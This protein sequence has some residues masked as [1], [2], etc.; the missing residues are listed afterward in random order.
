MNMDLLE[1][2]R[3]ALQN[4]QN[5]ETGKQINQAELLEALRKANKLL[6][7][8]G[9]VLT[10]DQVEIIKKKLSEGT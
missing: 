3:I 2:Q 8:V 9:E 4:L 7:V 5:A 10:P 6:K 1:I